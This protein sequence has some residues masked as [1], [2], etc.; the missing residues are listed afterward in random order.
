MSIESLNPEEFINKIS[1]ECEHAK[2]ILYKAFKVH[3]L[4]AIRILHKLHTEGATGEKIVARYNQYGSIEK[5]K[6]YAN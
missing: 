5:F 3:G 2:D 6:E 4:P 1:A